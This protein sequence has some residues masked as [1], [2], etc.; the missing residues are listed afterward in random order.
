MGYDWPE[1]RCSNALS[2][3]PQEACTKALQRA[4]RAEGEGPPIIDK[5]I[6]R[7]PERLWPAIPERSH[8][9]RLRRRRAALPVE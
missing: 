8:P 4:E 2:D 9:M 1:P 7:E 3:R 5:R 6:I